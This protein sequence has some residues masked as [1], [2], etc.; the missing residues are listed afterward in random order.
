MGRHICT[1]YI[2]FLVLISIHTP[3]K[4]ATLDTA[5]KFIQ[6]NI[7][8]HAPVK[9][10]TIP[11]YT[12]DFRQFD[13]YSRPREGGDMHDFNIFRSQVSFLFTPPRR[14]RRCCNALEILVLDFY[15]RPREG[16]DY[17]SLQ[18]HVSF[19]YFY[20][21]PREGGDKEGDRLYGNLWY[22]YSRPRE[23]GDSTLL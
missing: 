7:S 8:I 6:T 4:G 9:G 12:R 19:S 5:L 13:F 16:G 11:A 23:G 18:S 1:T 22:F 2:L 14:G 20:S 21:R 3:A 10:A 17:E 15:S